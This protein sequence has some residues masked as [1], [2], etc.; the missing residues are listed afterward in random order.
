MSSAH[1]FFAVLTALHPGG[2]DAR[3][4]QGTT[5]LAAPWNFRQREFS[6]YSSA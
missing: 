2:H 5:L 3:H 1:L 4:E 6:F